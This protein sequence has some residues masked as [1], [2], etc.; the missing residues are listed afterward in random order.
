MDAPAACDGSSAAA[1]SAY[2]VGAASSLLLP[3]LCAELFHLSP[4]L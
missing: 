1:G 4:K 3:Q 2:E